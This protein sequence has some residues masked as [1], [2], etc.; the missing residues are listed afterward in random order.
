MKNSRTA[1]PSHVVESPA[2][3]T[4]PLVEF[5]VDTKAEAPHAERC[6]AHGAAPS[7]GLNEA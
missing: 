6:D 3:R 5:P 4:L 1:G 7:A 2:T